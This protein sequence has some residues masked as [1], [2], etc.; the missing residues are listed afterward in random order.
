MVFRFYGHSN[1]NFFCFAMVHDYRHAS[2][3]G[4]ILQRKYKKMST[5]LCEFMNDFGLVSF[6]AMNIED[7]EVRDPHTTVMTYMS[8]TDCISAI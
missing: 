2:S 4:D 1:T 5:D 3:R 6:T 7:A 8:G